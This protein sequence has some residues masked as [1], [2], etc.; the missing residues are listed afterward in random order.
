[1]K[2]VNIYL[3]RKVIYCGFQN[4]DLGFDVELFGDARFGQVF[5]SLSHSKLDLLTEFIVTLV[6]FH[7]ALASEVLA[8]DGPT[9]CA[10]R[11]PLPPRATKEAAPGRLR[12]VGARANNLRDV[13][14]VLSH[15]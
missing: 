6:L 11:E 8:G 9:A 3:E 5:A 13:V 2:I 7:E 15:D 4:G 14:V 1:M 12:I 10:L